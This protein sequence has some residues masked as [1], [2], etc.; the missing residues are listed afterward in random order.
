M[1]L[2]MVMIALSSLFT[3]FLVRPIFQIPKSLTEAL[4]IYPIGTLTAFLIFRL[5]MN[6]FGFVLLCVVTGLSPQES[7]WV[8][9]GEMS[10]PEGM[11]Q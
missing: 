7:Y 1:P 8:L 11:D 10:L 2:L 4:F 3:Y 9:N 6:I 5:T